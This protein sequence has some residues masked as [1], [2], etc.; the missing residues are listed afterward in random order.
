MKRGGRFVVC[1]HVLNDESE[2]GGWAA[3]PFQYFWMALGWSFWGGRC[4]LIRDTKGALI[5]AVE[6]DGG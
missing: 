1:E 6:L 4:E 3:R 2:L 5:K